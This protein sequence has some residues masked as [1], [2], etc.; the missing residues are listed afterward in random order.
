MLSSGFSMN[1][2]RAAAQILVLA[3]GTTVM[4]SFSAVCSHTPSDDSGSTKIIAPIA[5]LPS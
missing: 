3:S 1:V 2:L 5:P 4:S